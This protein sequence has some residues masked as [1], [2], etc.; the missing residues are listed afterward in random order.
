[1]CECTSISPGVTYLPVPSM[2]KASAGDSTEVPT[3]AI[4]PSRISTEP[5]AIVGPAAVM[6]VALRIRVVRRGNGLYVLGKGSALGNEVPPGPGDGAGEAAAWAVPEADSLCCGVCGSCCVAN[7]S[8]RHAQ[9][10]TRII[11]FIFDFLERVVKR[12]GHS[13]TNRLRVSNFFNL[14]EGRAFDVHLQSAALRDQL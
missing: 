10:T 4:F 1:M 2:I 5:F 11:K 7:A 14:P 6:I 8:T 13:L 3:A 12:S 9:T